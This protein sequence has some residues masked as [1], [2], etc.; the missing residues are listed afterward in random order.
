MPELAPKTAVMPI[1]NPKHVEK[2]SATQPKPLLTV[3]G[4]ALQP[5]PGFALVRPIDEAQPDSY[6]IEKRLQI[7]ELKTSAISRTS[8]T[9]AT[10][11][12]ST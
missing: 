9:S 10:I 4:I 5:I 1:A 7:V 3:S 2:A 8:L 11:F 6:T 12:K